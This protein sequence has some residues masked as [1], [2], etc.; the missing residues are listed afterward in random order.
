[1]KEVTWDGLWEYIKDIPNTEYIAIGEFPYTG[2]Y[3]DKST[4]E[5]L[6][7]EVPDY[8]NLGPLKDKYKYYIKD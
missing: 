6:A 7:K 8:E 4:R 3:R 1:M 5:I 2:I